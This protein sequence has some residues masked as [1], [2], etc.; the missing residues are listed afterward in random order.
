MS[1]SGLSMGTP[2]DSFG[3]MIRDSAERFNKAKQNLYIITSID[4]LASVKEFV[5]GGNQLRLF[6]PNSSN[7]EE[8]ENHL[9]SRLSHKSK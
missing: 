1:E 7:K 2:I 9:L 5:Q 3:Q 6:T 4:C 8:M